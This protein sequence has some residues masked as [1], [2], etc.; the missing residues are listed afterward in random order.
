MW[1][2]RGVRQL[3]L[4]TWLHICNHSLSLSLFR[5]Q[6]YALLRCIKH[7]ALACLLHSPCPADLMHSLCLVSQGLFC[8][9]SLPSTVAC[10]MVSTWMQSD[11][12]AR[13]NKINSLISNTNSS[14]FSVAWYAYGTLGSRI[15]FHDNGCTGDMLVHIDLNVGVRAAY[16]CML[17][18]LERYWATFPMCGE[19]STQR[20]R[21]QPD[22]PPAVH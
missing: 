9:S 22:F 10:V 18:D 1:R 3:V 20:Q 7:H 21:T 5:L 6:R 2:L 12:C 17:T 13:R 4:T 11:I 8:H 14:L 16:P 19:Q 15:C